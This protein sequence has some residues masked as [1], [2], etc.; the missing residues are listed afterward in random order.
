MINCAWG[1]IVWT[2]SEDREFFRFSATQEKRPLGSNHSLATY[3]KQPTRKEQKAL[4]PI[5]QGFAPQNSNFS[6]FSMPLKRGV[7]ERRCNNKLTTEVGLTTVLLRFLK[8]ELKP[9]CTRRH[10]HLRD[11][12]HQERERWHLQV[13][14]S[15]ALFPIGE[16]QASAMRW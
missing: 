10:R 12:S 1:S 9:H 3:N 13:V 14:E 8:N 6:N 4:R 5:S 2:R 11:H 15:A 7:E 16:I